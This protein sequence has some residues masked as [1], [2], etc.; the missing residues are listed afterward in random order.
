MSTPQKMDMHASQKIRIA[1]ILLAAI[2]VPILIYNQN[3]DWAMNISI[4]FALLEITN[5]LMIS[6]YITPI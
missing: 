6:G 3:Y 2:S 1:L 5:A 4:I